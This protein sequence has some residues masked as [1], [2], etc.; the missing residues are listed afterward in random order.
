MIERALLWVVEHILFALLLT[1]TLIW[2]GCLALMGATQWAIN[3]LT[4]WKSTN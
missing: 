3:R 2:A 1:F 4:A